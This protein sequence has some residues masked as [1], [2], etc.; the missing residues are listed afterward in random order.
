MTLPQMFRR[1]SAL[2]PLV[3]SGLALLTLVV[4]F[5]SS[6]LQHQLDEGAAAHVW[7]LLM[8]GQLPFIAYFALRW[9]RRAVR[10]GLLVLVVQ[11]VAAIVAFAPVYLLRL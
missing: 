3:L 11:L 6:G 5:A 1:P 4:A 9:I 8:A 7:Q 10:I 2:V